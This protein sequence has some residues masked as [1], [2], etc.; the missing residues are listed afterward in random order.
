MSRPHRGSTGVDGGSLVPRPRKTRDE[1]A[2]MDRGADQPHDIAID[3]D[4]D[5]LNLDVAAWMD[6]TWA[7][8]KHAC[9]KGNTDL[10]SRCLKF[11]SGVT[12]INQLLLAFQASPGGRVEGDQGVKS[13]LRISHNAVYLRIELVGLHAED[14]RQPGTRAS[15]DREQ[16]NPTVEA[17]P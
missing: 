15:G 3:G 9:N 6:K 10:S 13:K 12:Q 14:F 2:G 1:Q 17:K 16:E 8:Y 11:L 7:L 5:A 4:E